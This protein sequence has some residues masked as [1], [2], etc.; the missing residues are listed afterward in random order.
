M[1]SPGVGVVAIEGIAFGRSVP[2][3][4]RR[5]GGP[6]AWHFRNSPGGKRR[7][8]GFPRSVARWKGCAARALCSILTARWIA[9]GQEAGRR[10]SMHGPYQPRERGGWKHEEGTVGDDGSRGR[11]RVRRHRRRAGPGHDGGHAAARAR[12]LLHHRRDLNRRR[13]PRPRDPAEHRA[14]GPGDRGAGQRHHRR[15]QNPH[16]RQHPR[17]SF[18]LSHARRERD[19]GGTR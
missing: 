14:G 18:F 5:G 3:G 1:H 10:G 11:R 19:R 12:R 7:Y 9:L 13:Q 4:G 2:A 17:R 8:D 16:Q 6:P 15:R